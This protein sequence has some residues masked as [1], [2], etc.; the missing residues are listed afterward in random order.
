M[1]LVGVIGIGVAELGGD[2][3]PEVADIGR[4]EVAMAGGG[5]FG[6]TKA[7]CIG[8]ASVDCAE[9]LRT[10]GHTGGLETAGSG[11]VSMAGL[12]CGGNGGAAGGENG[13]TDCGGNG[14]I[15]RGGKIGVGCAEKVE[16]GGA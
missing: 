2:W 13:G 9:N 15:D 8:V 4:G 12:V 5:G 6:G 14:S 10:V 1:G 7:G 11:C 3:R 16:R